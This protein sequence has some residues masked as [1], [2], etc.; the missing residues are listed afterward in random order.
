MVA[1]SIPGAVPASDDSGAT[2]RGAE[3]VGTND[4]RTGL[5]PADNMVAA[6]GTGAKGVRK[7][8]SAS[9]RVNTG[10]KEAEPDGPPFLI[11]SK[12]DF[13]ISNVA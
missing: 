12:D 2:G 3:G 13:L 9:T 1:I 10:T 4:E 6:E 11:A 7:E 8:R 5:V